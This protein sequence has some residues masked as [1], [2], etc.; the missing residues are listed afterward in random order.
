MLW[1]LVASTA[2]Q[3]QE[4]SL[5]GVAEFTL[6]ADELSGLAFDSLSVLVFASL[7]SLSL[8]VQGELVGSV[9]SNLRFGA[10]G[11]L[12]ELGLDLSSTLIVDPSTSSFVSWESSAAIPSDLAGL[13][14]GATLMIDAV[15]ASSNLLLTGSLP[16]DCASYSG[17]VRFGVCPVQLWEIAADADWNAVLCDRPAKSSIVLS[18]PTGFE[19][20]SVFLGDIELI[21][22]S[23]MGLGSFLDLTF[24]F[25]P[26]AK[27][28]APSLRFE[29]D[30]LICPG[31]EL[32]AE[33]TWSTSPLR[34]DGL[35]FSGLIF[36][37]AIGDG[38]LEIAE[39]F[40][41]AK[42]A[43]ITG[44]AEY[45]EKIGVYGPLPSC[46][47]TPG[48]FEINAYFERPP[49]VSGTL[50]GWGLLEAEGEIRLSEHV[51][52]LVA[53]RHASTSPTWAIEATA[54]I[55]W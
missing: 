41:D 5:G 31:V 22:G 53:I 29:T 43:S 14:I 21:E 38:G 16:T 37:V 48:S 39:S 6:A 15:P 32:L 10:S 26:D 51:G 13:E 2:V 46:C 44:K 34:I 36:D 12:G 52:F 49:I 55:L 47:G 1:M 28:V 27:I 20:L 11:V 33:V 45:F 3:A 23:M 35:A 9:F 4:I 30:W 8:Q 25:T 17:R 18:C 19:S 40:V 54:Q 7:C 50:F 24:T 42:N